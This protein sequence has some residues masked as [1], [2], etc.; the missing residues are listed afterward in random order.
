MSFVIVA[1]DAVASVASDLASVGSTINEANAAAAGRTTSLLAAGGDEVSAAVAAVF[2]AQAQGY[3]ALSAQAA[4][5][6][7]EFVQALTA[8]GSSYARAEGAAAAPLQTL[9]AP[10]NTCPIYDAIRQFNEKL[11]ITFTNVVG[12][13]EQPLVPLFER[14]YG[15]PVPP[16]VPLPA[17]IGGA[18][19]LILSG[20][21]A[22]VPNDYLLTQIAKQYNLPGGFGAVWQPSQFFP[23]SPHLGNLTFGQSISQGVQYLDQAIQAEA[24][25]NTTNITVWTTSQSSVVATAEI[26]HLMS[27]GAPFQNQLQFVLTGNLNN[28]DGGILER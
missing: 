25:N 14:A 6:H 22:N 11:L 18:V 9:L 28:P 15:P 10:I 3:Q 16:P 17:P 21:E 4:A 23:L 27:I 19:S 24:G 12:R 1:P 26:R 2:V 13:L 7:Q 5:F 8:A 20:T